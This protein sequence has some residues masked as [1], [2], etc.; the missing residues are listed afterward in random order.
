MILARLFWLA[1]LLLV[2][3]PRPSPAQAP[4]QEPT[5]LE[6]V[7]KDLRL[8]T[9]WYGL[10]IRGAKIGW[11]RSE[12][13]L[14][15][16]GE[17][18][19]VLSKTDMEMKITSLGR[20]GITRTS[21][22]HEFEASPP[23]RLVR[24]ISSSINDNIKQALTATRTGDGFD[25]VV[26]TG[27]TV[28]RRRIADLDYTLGD[29]KAPDVWLKRNPPPGT[30]IVVRNLDAESL[31]MDIATNTL[32]ST[33][34]TRIAGVDLTVHEVKSFFKRSQMTVV[35]K[36]DEKLRVLHMDMLGFL[37]A[38]L[39]TEAQAKNT[40]F[41]ADLFALSSVKSDRQLGPHERITSVTMEVEGKGLGEWIKSGPNQAVEVVREGRL[42]VR[43]GPK[44]VPPVK[45]T[46]AE[47]A[48]SI[49]ETV[50][51]P[52][53]DAKVKALA[54]AAVGNAATAR[55][56]LD[57]IVAF[58][59]AYITPSLDPAPPKLLDLIE[60]KSGD[61]K[62]YA[63]LVVALARATGLP[64]REISGLLYLGDAEQAFG[65]HA[66]AEVAINGVW[67]PVDASIP[68]TRLGGGHI[69]FGEGEAG[70][71][72]FSALMGAGGVFLHVVDIDTAP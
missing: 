54:A 24:V 52:V 1:L 65:G 55:E 9:D 17:A 30:S 11:L 66:W 16:K 42:R 69:R 6:P 60:R 61:C 31:E 41:S 8:A 64:A 68:L 34:K 57:R 44:A 7:I 38:R 51:L 43:L 59:S 28:S 50:A 25:V 40:T 32:L 33:R 47:V 12:T 58:V 39:E 53:A 27:G 5:R 10:Y 37:E 35:A 20:Q 23:F 72:A 3:A 62:A 71:S 46:P 15:G 2:A 49:G 36:I 19:R 67:V 29:D 45:A 26:D 63:M 13:A 70:L 14:A 22:T 56:R 4:S 21:T 18:K 48:A